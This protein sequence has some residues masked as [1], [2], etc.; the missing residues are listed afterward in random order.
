[1]YRASLSH[2][3]LERYLSLLIEKNLLTVKQGYYTT[4]PRGYL[5]IKSFEELT[6][7]INPEEET[8]IYRR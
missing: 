7:L 4:T 3:Q 8:R 6:D 1:M 2:S 5:F